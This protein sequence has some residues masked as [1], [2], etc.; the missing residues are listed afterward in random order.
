MPFVVF[1]LCLV[2]GARAAHSASSS[3][4]RF[5]NGKIS[6]QQWQTYLSE[7]RSIP[8]IR[9]DNREPWLLVCDSSSERSMWTFTRAGHS[10]HPAVTKGVLVSSNVSGQTLIGIDRSGYY[11]GRHEAFS[12]WMQEF[13]TLD[14]RQVA[15]WRA[16]KA[17]MR[18]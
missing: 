15:E 3:E 17:P 12:K 14:M 16:E 18:R 7:V 11:A 2:F 10:A 5:P 9:C 8:G 4:P 13:K 6:L 1:M